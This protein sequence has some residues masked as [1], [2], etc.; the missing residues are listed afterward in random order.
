MDTPAIHP[1]GDNF[2]PVIPIEQETDIR[3]SGAYPFCTDPSCLCHEDQS[4]IAP[5]SSEVADGLL[6]PSE[7]LRIVKGEMP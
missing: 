4:L 7:A 5:V 3:H 2:I 6:T 1:Y